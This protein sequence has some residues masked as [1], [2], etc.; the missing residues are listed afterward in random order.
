MILSSLL[1]SDRELEG[2]LE[3]NKEKLDNA[4]A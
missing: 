1:P 2:I 3:G 4:D